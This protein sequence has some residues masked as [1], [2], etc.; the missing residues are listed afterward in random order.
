MPL[1][2]LSLFFP[3]RNEAANLAALVAEA[4]DALPALATRYEVILVDDGSTDDTPSVAARLVAAHPGLVFVVRH[5]HGRGYGGALRSGFAAARM[6]QI[7]FTDGDRQF[8]VAD[9]APLARL[10]AGADGA[11]PNVVVGYRVD[12]A[13]PFVRRLYARIYRLALRVFYGLQLR[14]VDCAAKMFRREALAGVAVESRGA[15]FSA[16]LMIKLRD[17]GARIVEVGVPHYPR[18][19]GSA[20]G[21]RPL[22]VLRAVRDFWRLR[23][24]LW[25]DRAAALRRGSPLL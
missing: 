25:L 10:L 8:R 5:E 12:R 23:F 1:D 18:T 22:V 15:F 2:A 9:L 14:D 19:D 11:A 7:A 16:E 21:A 17:R 20:T 13:D 24:A 4:L 6:E 3:C